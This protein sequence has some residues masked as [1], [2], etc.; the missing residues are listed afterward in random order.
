MGKFKEL[1]RKAQEEHK[2][3]QLQRLKRHYRM[4]KQMMKLPTL[5]YND[6]TKLQRFKQ[7]AKKNFG[8]IFVDAISIG[9]II[10]T[11]VM[12]FRT[13]VKKG[14][15]AAGKFARALADAGKK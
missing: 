10:T 5:W 1:L 6:L 8:E 4:W 2:K 7:W 12:N 14:A 3:Q 11:I 15:R 13:A 9:G